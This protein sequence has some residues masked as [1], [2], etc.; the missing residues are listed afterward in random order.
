M[1]FVLNIS[2]IKVFF[3]EISRKIDFQSEYQERK[4]EK[5]HP[6]Q[7]NQEKSKSEKVSFIVC[8]V[9]C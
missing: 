7:S 5:V 2:Y 1:F 8:S 6:V 9:G 3:D 4:C